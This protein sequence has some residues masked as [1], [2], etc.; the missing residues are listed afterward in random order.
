MP[1]LFSPRNNYLRVISFFV[2]IAF[3]LLQQSC[4]WFF[5]VQAR[6]L[7]EVNS[8]AGSW[9]SSSKAEINRIEDFYGRVFGAAGDRYITDWPSVSAIKSGAVSPDRIPF[10]DYWYPERFGGTNLNGALNR[11]DQAFNA[12]ASSAAGWESSEHAAKE[13][14]WFGHCNGTSATVSRFQNPSNSVSRPRGCVPGTDPGCVVFSP[15]D[16]RAL[17]SEINM[18]ALS[19]FV[20][21]KRCELTSEQLNSRPAIRS[22]P[23]IKDACDDVDPGS[24]HVAL[25]NFIGRKKQPVM[26]DYNMDE[27]VWNYPIYGFSYT[28]SQP[29]TEAQALE[30]LG[31]AGSLSRWIFNDDAVSWIRVSMT[32]TYREALNNLTGAGTKPQGK[33]RTYDYILELSDQGEIIG[34][35]WVG[36]SRLSHPDFLWLAFEAVEVNESGHIGNPNIR[37]D[38]VHQLW[39]DSVGFD[40]TDPFRDEK[41]S[42]DLRF[43]PRP[44]RLWGTAPKYYDITLDGRK[45]G[46]VFGGKPIHLKIQLDSSLVKS[47]ANSRVAI[48]LN[49]QQLA[50]KSP[51]ASGIAEFSFLA[52]AALN[53]LS[54]KWE[55]ES[56][57]SEELDWEFRFYAFK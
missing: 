45:T 32:I 41:N 25:V 57:G 46:T 28:N 22:N 53:Y 17:L 37:T 56:I 31:Y 10:A 19:K 29:L 50:S 20:S 3:A 48:F 2:V 13:P 21:G 23:R 27:E 49:G 7:V 51:N 4:H 1:L 9:F 24:F 40:Q 6:N 35:E 5:E 34:G 39:A 33:G 52:P 47:N 8:Y 44:S 16:I 26:F 42:Y 15:S 14:A 43:Y 30:Q 12:G 54:L 55:H 18:S 11:Y 38:K 36:A